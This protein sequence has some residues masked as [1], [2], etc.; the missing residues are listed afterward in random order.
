MLSMFGRVIASIYL[1]LMPARYLNKVYFI[2]VLIQALG[3]AL[4]FGMH[5]FPFIA[6]LLYLIGLLIFGLGRGVSLFPYLLLL[7]HFS[8]IEDRKYV[9]MWFGVAELGNIVAYLLVTFLL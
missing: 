1:T 8:S 4:I 5:F 7:N 9:N 6:E 3:I 2:C